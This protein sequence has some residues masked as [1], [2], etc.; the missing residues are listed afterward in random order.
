MYI[1]NKTSLL[2]S[3]DYSITETTPPDG[4]NEDEIARQT[5]FDLFGVGGA[6]GWGT[7]VLTTGGDR[8]AKIQACSYF[9]NRQAPTIRY[10]E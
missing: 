7:R 6:G 4:R 5:P 2:R 3:S 10:R 1:I 8:A 9:E